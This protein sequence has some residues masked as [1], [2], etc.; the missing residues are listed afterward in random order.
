MKYLIT[1]GTG[2]IGSKLV[3]VLLDAGH[4][5]TV[6][7]RKSS[8]LD[9][10]YTLI[11]DLA[12]IP[13]TEEIDVIINL[14]GKPIDCRWTKTNKQKLID[15]RLSITADL[16]ALIDRLPYKPRVL[17][18]ASAVGYYGPG[19]DGNKPHTAIDE[20]S[21]PLSSFTH[22]LCQQW[23]N[24]A[25]KAG[26][27]GVRVC[28]MRLGVVLGKGGGYIKKVSLPFRLGLGGKLGHGKQTFPWIHIDDVVS[29]I[30]Y[31]IHNKQCHGAYN[32]VA[33]RPITNAGMT[34]ELGKTLKRPTLFT[35]PSFLIRTIFGEMGEA[36]LLKGNAI[37]P[38]RLLEDGY[39]FK[40][41][42]IDSALENIFGQ[43]ANHIQK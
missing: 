2:F 22:D 5:V 27:Y 41:D 23:E 1:G 10:R 38:K 21:P 24:E 7:S 13:K 26:Q 40:Y 9:H 28:I 17:I 19:H 15:S 39:D 29:G 16:I 14:A 8:Q 32:F 4:E 31:L 20:S 6:L 37:I 35:L 11:N 33:P 18:S 43:K 12:S 42:E 3:S 34:A 36:L 25:S 30:F